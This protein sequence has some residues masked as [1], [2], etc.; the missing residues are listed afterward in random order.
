MAYKSH[1]TSRAKDRI[2]NAKVVGKR[3]LLYPKQFYDKQERWEWPRQEIGR[4]A[5]QFEFTE[6]WG[7]SGYR[8]GEQERA[9]QKCLPACVRGRL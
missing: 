1:R 9:L 7:L 8:S 2:V 5:G 3:L 4:L 6:P